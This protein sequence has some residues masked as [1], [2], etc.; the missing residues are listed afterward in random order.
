MTDENLS[1]EKAGV[2]IAEGNEF[3]KDLGQITK[4]SWRTGVMNGIGG[5][6][7]F[8]DLKACGFEDPLLLSATDGV[9]TKIELARSTNIYHGLGIDLVAMCANDL[10]VHGGQPL[11]FLD[12]LASG[13]LDRANHLTIVESMVEGCREAGCALIGGETAEMPG[14]YD[15]DKFDLAGFCVGAVERS[16][17][18][19]SNIMPG[20]VVLGVS[21]SGFHS[22]GYSLIRH[23]IVEKGMQLEE[24]INATESFAEA[25]MRPTHIYVQPSMD[26]LDRKLVKG[27]AHITGGGILENLPRI[28]PN[29]LAASIDRKLIKQPDVVTHFLDACPLDLKE[30]YRT[31]NM[32]IGFC[33][34]CH[35][36]QM[37]AVS[38]AYAAHGHDCYPIGEITKRNEG[39]ALLM[40]LG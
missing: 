33:V 39:P 5:F 32:G 40:D 7:G 31:F 21:S 1:Y 16:E 12:Y 6:A 22:N 36:D 23:A 9:G 27:F 28:L 4:R 25:L 18:L 14:V 15:G 8:F 38:A 2:N 20:D 11:F 17:Q 29:H 3:V 26:C 35:P 30:A 24:K 34:V 37:G 13:K 10:V 19:P